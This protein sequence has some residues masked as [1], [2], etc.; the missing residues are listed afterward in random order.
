MV[1]VYRFFPKDVTHGCRPNLS[2]PVFNR[3]QL[4]EGN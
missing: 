3:M 2:V 1:E 4:I